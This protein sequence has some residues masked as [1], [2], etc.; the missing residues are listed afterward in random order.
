MSDPKV[1]RAA[2]Y[3]RISSE[4][5]VQIL[6]NQ[7][8]NLR[9]YCEERGFSLSETDVYSEVASGTAEK[10]ARLNDLLSAATKRTRP[11]DLVVFTSLSRMTRGGVEAALYVLRRLEVSGVGWHII[12]QPSLNFDSTTP[13]LAKDIVLAVLT[14]IDKDYRSRIARATK[15]AYT[16]RLNL[17]KAAGE[18][19]RWGR[20]P[21]AKDRKNR[22]RREER[23]PPG[24]SRAGD[25]RTMVPLVGVDQR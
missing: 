6:S 10:Q 1:T 4:D 20:P 17:A 14:A 22:K 15:A 19:V 24:S 21:G 5:E 25:G 3:A 7:L 9:R 8:D 16:R 11:F 12:E 2:V 13:S 18:K 23:G